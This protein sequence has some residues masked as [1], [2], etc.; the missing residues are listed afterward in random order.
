MLPQVSFRALA[1]AYCRRSPCSV[2]FERNKKTDNR[3]KKS[4][5]FYK[6]SYDKH[7]SLDTA[8]S[9]GLTGNTFHSACTDFTDTKARSDSSDTCTDSGSCECNSETTLFNCLKQNLS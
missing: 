4:N 5:R 8:G 2:L 7:G 1:G 9:F 6:S 3:C